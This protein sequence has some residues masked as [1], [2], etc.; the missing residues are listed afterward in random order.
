M[1]TPRTTR[2][3]I[4]HDA[5][6]DTYRAEVH[7]VT[8]KGWSIAFRACPLEAAHVALHNAL[9]WGAIKPYSRLHA[10]SRAILR[11]ASPAPDSAAHHPLPV[12][13]ARATMTTRAS[14]GSPSVGPQEEPPPP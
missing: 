9:I 10:R 6:L 13:T 5:F 2:L 11:A 14:G 4:T 12:A 8:R 7:G 1:A 3:S